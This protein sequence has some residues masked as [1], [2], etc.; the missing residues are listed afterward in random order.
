MT[1]LRR[2]VV[3]ELARRLRVVY[4]GR[5][6]DRSWSTLHTTHAEHVAAWALGGPLCPEA[7]AAC[8]ASFGGVCAR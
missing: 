1:C 4:G 7:P 8:D 6:G 2:A 5:R 3:V